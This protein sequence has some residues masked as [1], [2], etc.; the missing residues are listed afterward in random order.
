MKKFSIILLIIFSLLIISSCHGKKDDGTKKKIASDYEV[1]QE[2]DETKNYKILFWSKNDSNS[3]QKDIYLR[4]IDEFEAIYPNI[5]IEMVTYYDYPSIYKDAL[6]NIGTNTP[7]DVCITYPDHVASYKE[8]QD[9]IV[10]LEK[11]YNDDKYGLGGSE[12]KF[13]SAGKNGVVEKFLNECYFAGHL[14]AIPF[15]RSSEA[16]Y[17][18]VDLLKELGFEVPEILTWDFVWEVCKKARV[19]HPYTN[20]NPLMY[21]STDNMA[22]QM[23]RQ[24][25]I[26]YSNEN[27]EIYLFNDQ[28]ANL[29]S[30]LM[31]YASA[32]DPR[33]RLFETFKRKSYPGNFY[34]KGRCVFAIDSTAGSTWLGT[35]APLLD[36]DKKEVANF[37]TK[38]MIVPQHD[39]TNPQM[40]SQGPS[41]CIFNNN[42]SGKVLASWLFVQYLL[43]KDIQ[44]SYAKTEGYIPVTRDALY[45]DE[46]QDYLNHEDDGTAE[47][48]K[49]KLDA[50]KLV[51]DNIDNT[52][53]TPVF[54]GSSLLRAGAG[55]LI[56]GLFDTSY[57][58]ETDKEKMEKINQLF[59][60]V[61]ALNRLEITSNKMPAISIVVL[62]LIGV[63]WLSLGGIMIYTLYQKRKKKFVS[64]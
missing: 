19:L 22:I 50:S 60:D 21:K 17:V 57:S 40:I 25:N 11:F 64:K 7:P 2:F 59:Y 1:P 18:N 27:G 12:I 20:F 24:Y 15:V 4:A 14:Y 8:G 47:Y 3:T 28:M 53:V 62:V 26:P 33:N 5:E 63:S 42:D 54:N 51:I 48:Y 44:M 30:E 58:G 32:K 29:L 31:D 10:P 23:A 56:E 37:E 16:C 34:N 46:Y 36:I 52:F 43:T 35:T 45:S 6:I 55:D 38:V 61:K 39:I 13:S 9:I 41:L 49:V